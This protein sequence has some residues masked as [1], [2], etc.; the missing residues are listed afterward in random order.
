MILPLTGALYAALLAEESGSVG[1][2]LIT[3]T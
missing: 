3:E 2:G 1:W